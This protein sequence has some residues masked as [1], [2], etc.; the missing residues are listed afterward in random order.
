MNKLLSLMMAVAFTHCVTASEFS[1][2]CSKETLDLLKGT[3]VE[4]VG[5]YR[6]SA[7]IGGHSEKGAGV[8]IGIPLNRQASVS[9]TGRVLGFENDH[10]NTE[11]DQWKGDAIDE[12]AIGIRSVLLKSQ[13]KALRLE[14]EGGG[15]RSQQLDDFGFHLGGYVVWQ[16]LK[17]GELRVGREIRTWLDNPHDHLTAFSFGFKF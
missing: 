6:Q 12:I 1:T 3:S 11:G 13:N 2:K 17:N 4:A 15:D 10:K 14:F 16:P 8:A 7:F 5:A 9:L